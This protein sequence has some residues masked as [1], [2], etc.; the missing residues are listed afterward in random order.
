MSQLK[1]G[2][3]KAV[4]IDQYKDLIQ[5]AVCECE[6]THK[7]TFNIGKLQS[8]LK[9]ICKAAEYDGLNETVINEL[10]DQTVPNKAPKIA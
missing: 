3:D 6:S 8:K 10:I 9:V 1:H 2:T 7:T 5:A 4:L